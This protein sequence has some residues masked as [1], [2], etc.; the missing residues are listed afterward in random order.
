MIDS[1]AQTSEPCPPF[2][3]EY[4]HGKSGPNT[5]WLLHFCSRFQLWAPSTFQQWHSGGAG[6]WK[7][8]MGTWHR[9]DFILCHLDW[10]NGL[11]ASWTDHAVDLGQSVVDHRPVGCQISLALQPKAGGPPRYD[12]QALR[13]PETW[14]IVDCALRNAT[15]I[16]WDLDVHQHAQQVRE[17]IHDILEKHIPKRPTRPRQS[18]ITDATWGLRR[19][20]LELKKSLD[21][22]ESRHCW[23]WLDW[24]FLCLKSH[25]PLR[26]FYI[27]KLRQLLRRERTMAGIRILLCELTKRTRAELKLDRVRH[28]QQLSEDC[29]HKPLHHIYK[30]LRKVGVGSHYRK[31]GTQPLP[32]FRKTNGELSQSTAEVAECWR[33]HCQTMEAGEVVDENR[34]LGW[35]IGS[36]HHRI[37]VPND[38]TNIP[39]LA[40]LEGHLRRMQPGKA[41]GL[42]CVPSDLCHHFPSSL[43]RLVYPILL[44]EYFGMQEAL[45]YKG[46]RLIYAYKGK[47]PRDDTGSYR[48]LMLT[49]VI[50]KAIRSTFRDHFLPSYRRFLGNT[51]YSAR[52]AGHVGQ[53]CLTLQLFCR[54]AKLCGQSAGII[55]LDIRAAYYSICR[56]L[57]SGWTGSDDQIGHIL[58]HFALPSSDTA[59][60]RKFLDVFGGATDLSDMSASHRALLS[61]LSTGTWFKVIGSELVT[62]THGGS[63]PGDGLA[64]LIF[65]FVFGRLLANLK[66]SLATKGLWSDEPWILPVEREQILDHL[67]EQVTVPCNLDVIWA[68]DLALAFRNDYASELVDDIKLV[69]ADLFDWCALFGMTPNTGRG[70]SEILL[71]LRGPH[72]REVRLQVFSG[73]SPALEISPQ[74]CPPMKLHLVHL[75]K[76]LGAQL[77]IGTKLLHEIRIRSGMMRTAYNLYRKKVFGNSGLGLKQ[78]GQLLES[79]IFSILRWNIG[80]WYELDGN[81]YTSVTEP[82]SSTL[83]EEP[84]W[85]LMELKRYG[86]GLTIKSSQCC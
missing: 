9:I 36:H 17:C 55:F 49:S 62:Q 5:A 74:R 12:L 6:T 30:E 60:L 10:Y 4:G 29:Q 84:A 8:P 70:K 54:H 77:H 82:Q 43:G 16:P 34:L 59:E 56:E 7:H 61:E 38:T 81:S 79:M 46:G 51:Y 15:D 19:H 28:L 35:V 33:Q 73:D 66:T 42:D 64:D 67:D 1:N 39:S 44:K 63:R 83:S 24:S 41:C 78:R 65:G 76:H 69:A 53:A 25:R 31:R 20:K 26:H 85:C 13:C 47:G 68:D 45:E 32:T 58:H 57:T 18:F 21:G 3:G 37:Q 11:I 80:G 2:I 50:G 52:A 22:L 40:D 75:Y 48:G 23:T 71:Q 27:P 72:S 14:S 86:R